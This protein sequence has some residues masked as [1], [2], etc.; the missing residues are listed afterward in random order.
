MIEGLARYGVSLWWW[1]VTLGAIMK[2]VGIYLRVSTDFQ[3]KEKQRRELEA[4]AARSGWQ[5]VDFYGTPG[6]DA[7]GFDQLLKDATARKLDM[8]GLVGGSPRSCRI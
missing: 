5:V 6:R 8:I 1:P 3:T 2:R 4:V 7:I